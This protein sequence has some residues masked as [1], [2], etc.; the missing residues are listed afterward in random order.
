VR[1]VLVVVDEDPLPALLLPPRGRDDVGAAALELARSGHG[2]EANGVGVPARGQPDVDVQPAVARRLGEADDAEL[3]QQRLELHG[4]RARLGEARA[5]LRVEVQA[6][7]V[8]VVGIVGAVGPDVE[9]QA[10][11]VDRPGDVRDVG[12]HERSRRRAVDRLDRRRL[13]PLRRVV[14]YALLEERGAAG[15]LR[16]ALHEHR[17]AAH[18]AHERL[19]RRGVV[20]HEV[21]LGLAALGEEHLGRAGDPHLATGKLEDLG[22]V[23]GHERYGACGSLTAP[24]LGAGADGGGTTGPMSPSGA[25][26][27]S[28]ITGA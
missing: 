7:L 18:R 1:R 21:E 25:S 22:V 20:A 9:A 26:S 8:G 19:G 5:G 12:R 23:A 28:M 15:A 2:G 4:R 27:R 24:R 10:G 3:V 11:Q 6:Q 14:R 13:Q 16:E 17:P